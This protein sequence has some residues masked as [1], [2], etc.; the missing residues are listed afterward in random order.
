[1]ITRVLGLLLVVSGALHF[2]FAREMKGTLES[3]IS[4]L[5]TGEAAAPV[6]FQIATGVACLLLGLAAVVSPQKK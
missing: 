1:M 5:F 2:W 4:S 3:Q 6:R